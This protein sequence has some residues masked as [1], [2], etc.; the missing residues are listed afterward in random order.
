MPVGKTKDA[1]WEVGASR[2]FPCTIDRAWRVLTS[3]AGLLAW[4]G[5]TTLPEEG[6]PRLRSL[7][8]HDR[9]RL[10]WTAPGADHETTLQVTVSPV[11]GQVKTVVNFHQEHLRDAEERAAMK[12]RWSSVLDE[13]EP[14][15]RSG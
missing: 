10:R 14:M 3:R 8:P 7:R 15:L 2:T 6:D 4:L 13:L 5:T 12:A 9:V 11:E 1:G